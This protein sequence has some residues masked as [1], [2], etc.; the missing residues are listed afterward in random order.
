MFAEGDDEET[1][2]IDAGP[3]EEYNFVDI[4]PTTT[5]DF[6]QLL[7]GQHD[8]G[9]TQ[10]EDNNQ[11][12]TPVQRNEGS[13]G[14]NVDLVL[15]RHNQDTIPV[16]RNEGSSGTNVELFERLRLRWVASDPHHGLWEGDA[17]LRRSIPVQRN[18]GSSGTNVELFERL[19]LRWVA[20]DPH[21]GLWEGDAQLRR[22][23]PR[24]ETGNLWAQEL[25]RLW[26]REHDDND[27]NGEVVR[28]N[29]PN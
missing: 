28:D 7:V 24:S 15:E 19:R 29:F 17:Q 20:S 8:K 13:S 5:T 11:D 6:D 2:S 25:H 10:G 12:T 1:L 3:D 18:E 23:H 16:Q 21:H 14:T 27:G 22:S 4:D 9:S 26:A